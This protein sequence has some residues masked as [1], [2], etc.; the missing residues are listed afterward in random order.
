M[1]MIM[2]TRSGRWSDPSVWSSGAMP[3]SGDMAHILSGHEIIYDVERDA[4]LSDVMSEMG[5]KL[6]WGTA[7]ETRLRVNTIML[8]GI[9]DLT[10]RGV[11]ATPGKPKHEIVFHPIAGKEPGAGTG[12]GLMCMG[13]TRIHGAPKAGRLFSETISLP[14]GSSQINLPGLS[15]SGWRVGDTIIILG[16]NLLPLANTDPHYTGPTT[17]CFIKNGSPTQITL[18]KYQFGEDEQRTIQAITGDTLTLDAPLTYEHTGM[19]GTLIDGQMVSVKPVV[20]NVSRSIR[21]RTATAA[22]DGALDPGAD[23]TV[24]Q[25]RAHSMFMR[26]PDVDLRYFETKNMGRTSTDPSLWVDGFPLK[27]TGTSNPYGPLLDK[28]GGVSIHDHNNV[29]GR[30]A[31]H[32]H[33]S[34]GPHLATPMVPLIGATAWAPIGGHP[35]PGWAITQHSTRAAIEDCV[36]SNVRGAGIVSELGNEI[37]QW[38]NNTVTGCRGDGDTTDW[39][40]RMENFPNHNGSSGVAYENQSRAIMQHGNIAGSSRYGWVYLHQKDHR[41]K[42]GLRGVDLRLADPLFKQTAESGEWWQDELIGAQGTQIPPFYDNYV[43]ACEVGFMVNHRLGNE[44]GPVKTPLVMERFHCLNVRRPWTVPRYSNTYY[45]KDCMFQASPTGVLAGSRAVTAGV[46][47]WDFSFTNC[48]FRNYEQD[49]EMFLNYEGF[50]IDIKHEGN[51]VFSADGYRTFAGARTHPTKNVMGEWVDHPTDPNQAIVRQFKSYSKSELP[52]P[53]PLEPY[54]RKLPANRPDGTPYPPVAWGENPYFVLGDGTNGAAST[55]PDTIVLTLTAGSARSMGKLYGIIR[56]SVGDRRYPDWQSNESFPTN[57]GVKNVYRDLMKMTPEQFV[58]FH[59]CF[60]DE[61]TWKVRTWFPIADRSSLVLTHFMVDWRLS[62]FMADFLAE[63]DLGG[64]PAE[65]EWPT[66][67]EKVPAPRS[68]TPIARSLRFLSRTQIEV[69][70]GK[71]FSH[72][73][74]PN[75]VMTK[76][77]IVG[78][79]AANL[80]AIRGQNLVWAGAQPAI[81]STPYEVVVRATDT[82]GNTAEAAHMVVV[83]S[84]ARVSTTIED[85]FDRPNEPLEA[86]P[87]YLRLTGEAGMMNITNNVVSWGNASTGIYDLG[88]LGTSE[89]EVSVNFLGAIQVLFRMVDENNWI[90][91][92]RNDGGGGNTEL[93]I[94]TG[95][96]IKKIANFSNVGGVTIIAKGQRLIFGVRASASG[97]FKVHYPKANFTPV[98]L[99]IL[100]QD[101]LSEPGTLLLPDYAPRGTKIGLRKWSTSSSGLALDNLSAKALPG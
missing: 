19:D 4:I 34:G 12:L 65:P 100:D 98:D 45:Q 73:L 79:A 89:Q 8:N 2:T 54:G 93:F 87:A 50:F 43:I 22:E 39:S 25:K 44:S 78:G 70:D 31:I 17:Y 40:S 20:S 26:Q 85:N 63:H 72:R 91:M 28:V 46:V 77:Q 10:D 1:A 71:A 15:K 99:K 32:L 94:C 67:L 51:G 88:S 6:T 33:W 84:S 52:F 5:S 83:I 57:F 27:V 13:P 42:R 47:T 7:K 16:T 35:I 60:L 18:N 48:L 101:H 11:S 41:W 49:V 97:E 61:D 64:A 81:R 3:G 86:N 38:V 30:Y 21:F 59:G 68:L 82:W 9:M 90:A 37:G 23:I 69:V 29:R 74:R 96:V 24:L 76:L 92:G 55:S 14:A 62:G 53:Y 36:V 75:E 56:D 80:F 66:R 95:G 58:M